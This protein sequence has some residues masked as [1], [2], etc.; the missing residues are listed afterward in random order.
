MKIKIERVYGSIPHSGD[1]RVLVDR[2]WPR[3]LSHEQLAINE[4]LKEIA[5]STT[6]RQWFGHDPKLWEEFR[7]KYLVELASHQNELHR[8]HTIAN[9]QPLV[10]LYGAKD[11]THNQAVVIKEALLSL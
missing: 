11:T 10:L 9:K 5:P 1:Y 8:L 7:Q 6:L 3:G 2:L 4:W